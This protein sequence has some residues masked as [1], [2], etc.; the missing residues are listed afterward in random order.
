M[1]RGPDRQRRENGLLRSNRRFA[2]VTL[3]C[4]AP[5]T[6]VNGTEFAV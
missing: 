5:Q 1:P 2:R 3:P 6:R 4:M